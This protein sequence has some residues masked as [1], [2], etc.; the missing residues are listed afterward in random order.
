M[1]RRTTLTKLER[2]LEGE[3]T[4]CTLTVE[5]SRDSLES[6]PRSILLSSSDQLTVWAHALG[7]PIELTGPREFR[8]PRRERES[9][10]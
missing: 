9:L 2:A 6:P 8:S 3:Y 10:R 1:G 4:T 7:S 5:M